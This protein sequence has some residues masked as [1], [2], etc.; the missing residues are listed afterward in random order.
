MESLQHGERRERQGSGQLYL[1]LVTKC[2]ARYGFDHGL[3]NLRTPAPKN[4]VKARLWSI[5]QKILA[6]RDIAAY[7]VVP[8]DA[9]LRREGRDWPVDAE[10]MIG[11]ERLQN[12]R[13]C[14]TKVI[15][16]DVPGDFIETGVWRGGACILMRAVLATYSVQDR[17][18]WLADSFRGLPAPSGL[19][20]ADTGDIRHTFDALAVSR[21]DVEENFRR[22]GLLDDQVQ[23]LGSPDVSGKRRDKPAWRRGGR[24]P[25]SKE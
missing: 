2:L 15:E 7:R 4:P 1:D 6:Q 12:I 3:S 10:T 22:Y 16:D 21:A 24:S 11:L 20:H 13:D 25:T 23:F 8:F 18:V 14:A 9:Q 5:V 17:T 19:Y